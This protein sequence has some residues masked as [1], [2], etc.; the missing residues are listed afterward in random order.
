MKRTTEVSE[1]QTPEACSSLSGVSTCQARASPIPARYY[2]YVRPYRIMRNFLT[3]IRHFRHFISMRKICRRLQGYSG[4]A[5]TP[6]A[7]AYSFSPLKVIWVTGQ[8]DDLVSL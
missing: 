8:L 3:V 7:R 5:D 6:S 4:L 2:V 1:N